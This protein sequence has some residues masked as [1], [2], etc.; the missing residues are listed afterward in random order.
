VLQ[1]EPSNL[2]SHGSPSS[3]RVIRAGP[4]RP[5]SG[6]LPIGR[7]HSRFSMAGFLL[8]ADTVYSQ[9]LVRFLLAA[10]TVDSQWLVSYWP[11]TR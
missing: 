11:Q 3:R 7:R 9:W 5:R 8:A 10:D 4:K 6:V 2:D 1:G